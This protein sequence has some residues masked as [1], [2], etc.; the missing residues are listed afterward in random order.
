MEENDLM[1]K[2]GHAVSWRRVPAMPEGCRGGRLSPVAGVGGTPIPGSNG[3][4]RKKWVWSY[5]TTV[6]LLL[7]VNEVGG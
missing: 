6:G 1:G 4:R 3:E 5:N 2:W 7:F